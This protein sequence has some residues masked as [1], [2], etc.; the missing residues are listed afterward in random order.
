MI[1]TSVIVQRVQC[2]EHFV[3]QIANGV[4]QRLQVLL[5]LV[6]FQGQLGAEQFA[7]NVAAVAGGQGQRQARSSCCAPGTHNM[8]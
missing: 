6:P 7:A 3:A 4:V 2:A 8:Y 1:D 5:I